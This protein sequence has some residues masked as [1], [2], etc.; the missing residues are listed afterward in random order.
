MDRT[1]QERA[2]ILY[3]TYDQND[4][5]VSL[6]IEEFDSD[7]LLIALRHCNLETYA[8]REG[9]IETTPNDSALRRELFKL[10]DKYYPSM[11]RTEAIDEYCD[12]LFSD[13][14]GSNASV[15]NRLCYL[16]LNDG[17]S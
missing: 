15:F 16:H 5:R 7:E 4:A 11:S 14:A 13:L 10:C 9:Y 6:F 3:R 1:I 12:E 8:E 2:D 17:L